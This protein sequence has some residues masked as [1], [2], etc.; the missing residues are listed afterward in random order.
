MRV[1]LIPSAALI[2]AELSVNIGK[3]PSSLYPYQSRAILDHICEKYAN[4]A[5]KIFVIAYHKSDL[6]EEYVRVKKLPVEIITLDNFGDLGFSIS[7]G[8]NYISS[9]YGVP[10][11]IYINYGDTL[12]SDS[13]NICGDTIY[14]DEISIDENWTYFKQTNGVLTEIYDKVNCNK[15]NHV[16]R[17][18]VGVFE[19]AN[20]PLF[21]STLTA[22]NTRKDIDSFYLAL[23]N[24][25]QIVPFQFIKCEEW[26][27]V[28]HNDKSLRAKREV[29]ARDFNVVKIDEKRG[30]LE[31]TSQHSEKFID[32]IKWYLSLPNDLKYLSPRIYNYSTNPSSPLI[33]MEY[34]GYPT[35]HELLVYGDLSQSKWNHIFEKLAFI[36]S[37]MN[38]Y[39]S[40]SLSQEKR[41][42]CMYDMYVTKPISRLNQLKDDKNFR[43]FFSN[44]ITINGV[45]MPPLNEIIDVLPDVVTERLLDSY[46]SQFSIIHGDLCFANILVETNYNF[47]RLIDPR[48]SFGIPGVYGDIRYDLAKLLHSL[49]GGYDFIIE[50]LVNVNVIDTEISCEFM[51][52]PYSLLNLFE[53]SF[54][55]QIEK[56]EEL[57][58]IESTIFLSMLPL[59]KN[60]LSRQYAMLATG[61]R[62]FHEV[63]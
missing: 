27:D 13:P 31:K 20:V 4:F 42:Q 24:Y 36:V 1:L 61:M 3:I 50:D 32:E 54:S 7:Y 17:V 14:Y 25:S 60:S 6:I 29:E 35:L 15:I 57:R 12:I 39:T 22:S 43:D 9:K 19:I 16:G 47:M 59:H 33:S 2:P 26:I 38:N 11:Q 55:K 52:K 53:H 44:E 30:I 63:Y 28:G 18:F 58:L 48:G 49:E 8:L 5:D 51:S 40:P 10:S 37:D 34:Y 41:Y 21:L 62:L 45:G 46:D 23:N 56:I